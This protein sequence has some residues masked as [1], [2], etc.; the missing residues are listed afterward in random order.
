[1]STLLD[2]F[3]TIVAKKSNMDTPYVKTHGNINGPDLSYFL[4]N[5]FP[6]GVIFLRMFF[7]QLFRE[8]EI[9]L[10]F[11]PTMFNNPRLVTNEDGSQ[12]LDVFMTISVDSLYRYYER[13][14]PKHYKRYKNKSQ[15]KRGIIQL[16]LGSINCAKFL[17]HHAFHFNALRL[18]NELTH[19]KPTPVEVPKFKTPEK[20]PSTKV[21]DAPKK[22]KADAEPQKPVMQV[23]FVQMCKRPM[24]HISLYDN[25]AVPTAPKKSPPCEVPNAE[26]RLQGI[27]KTMSALLEKFAAFT[28]NEAPKKKRKI[29]DEDDDDLEETECEE[30]CDLC[31]DDPRGMY[32]CEDIYI[33]CPSC[34]K[35]TDQ[36]QRRHDDD[37]QS[38]VNRLVNGYHQRREKAWW[39]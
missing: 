3:S 5:D 37:E 33:P 24:G 6:H 18:W 26:K 10:Q 14:V 25:S 4:E 12:S 28:K 11:L 23:P 19:I 2:Q 29:Y 17:G 22:R 31:H 20:R 21:P 35:S 36:Q 39:W 7:D 27:E 15:I 13:F 16:L 32:T 9:R 1:M 38:E 8:G 30:D 34:S